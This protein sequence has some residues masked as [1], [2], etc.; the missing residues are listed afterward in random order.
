LLQISNSTAW[1]SWLSR[2]SSH[3]CK[4]TKNLSSFNVPS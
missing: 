3:S 4:M 2:E 1:S